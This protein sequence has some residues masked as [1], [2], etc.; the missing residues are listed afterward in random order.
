VGRGL[1][2]VY[3]SLGSRD[4]LRG[5]RISV[6]GESGVGVKIDRDGCFVVD[7]GGEQRVLESGEIAYER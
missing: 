7:V 1:D 5:R 3:D 4:F 6:N 2:G